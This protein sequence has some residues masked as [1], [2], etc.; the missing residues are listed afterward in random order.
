MTTKELVSAANK[1]VG[2]EYRLSLRMDVC[3]K[4]A[5]AYVAQWIAN[6]DQLTVSCAA[7][8]AE[9]VTILNVEWNAGD[10]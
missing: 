7:K 8:A 6:Q 5:L 3:R 2:R 1:S 10:E 9:A 4:M